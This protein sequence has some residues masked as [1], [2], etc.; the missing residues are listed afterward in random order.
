MDYTIKEIP[1]DYHFDVKNRL[2]LCFL[3]INYGM[4]NDFKSAFNLNDLQRCEQYSTALP[5]ENTDWTEKYSW[6]ILH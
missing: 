5:F 4:L 3:V 2:I 1:I 6:S